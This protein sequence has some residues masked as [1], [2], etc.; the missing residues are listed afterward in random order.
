MSKKEK[1]VSYVISVSVM[2]GC[3]RHIKVSSKDSLYQLGLAILDAFGFDNDHLDVFFMDNTMWSNYDAYYGHSSEA[4][5][6]DSEDYRLEDVG[7]FVG[8]KFKYLFD[9]G[10]SWVFQCKVLK[11]L[12]EK[13]EDPEV[14][15]SKGEAP[16]QYDF[17]DEDEE[18]YEDDEDEDSCD[19]DD[20]E[21]FEIQCPHCD[22][23]VT[24]NEDE[25][26]EAADDELAIRCPDCG[27]VIFSD[28]EEGE[29]EDE[30]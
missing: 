15:R 11:V 5:N 28:D 16:A 25:L 6:R 22:R 7:L 18:F 30:D 10:D 8:K 27:E 17:Y 2:T 13:S 26:A 3:Y 9:F 23:L 1:E 12:D 21:E 14:V 4:E 19:C 29:S 24:I 20:P